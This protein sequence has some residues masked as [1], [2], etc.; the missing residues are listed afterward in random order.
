[1][2]E[3]EAALEFEELLGL[4]E[5]FF[6]QPKCPPFDLK[7]IPRE[8]RR[9]GAVY[10]AVD[11]KI[12]SQEIKDRRAP[13]ELADHNSQTDRRH[14]GNRLDPHYGFQKAPQDE[15]GLLLRERNIVE[16]VIAVRRQRHVREA[17]E[18][19]PASV[20][21]RRQPLEHPI[22]ME[23][24]EV[25]GEDQ[26]RIVDVDDPAAKSRKGADPVDGGTLTDET[27]VIR[28]IF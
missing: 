19:E 5:Y 23:D 18:I 13:A 2:T 8:V 17:R 14:E 10:A 20:A 16:L 27:K 4:Q 25:P 22:V 24:A 1:M 21:G 3:L 7:G 6:L 26:F 9:L 28:W 11:R 15:F 12:K